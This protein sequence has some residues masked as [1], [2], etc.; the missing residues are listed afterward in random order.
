[1]EASLATAT[2]ILPPA[3]ALVAMSM[4]RG[5]GRLLGMAMQIGLVPSLRSLPPKGT[6]VLFDRP[7]SA[8]ISPISPAFAAMIG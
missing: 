3:T 4:K 2:L 6:T 1:M 5:P 8:V 7:E